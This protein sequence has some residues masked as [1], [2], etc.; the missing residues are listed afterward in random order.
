M[1][2]IVVESF[3]SCNGRLVK[4]ESVIGI[5]SKRSLCLRVRAPL[6]PTFRP[7]LAN[8]MAN[9]CPLGYY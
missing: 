8:F 5:C 4:W 3:I 1:S 9:L 7:T 6:W 2:V